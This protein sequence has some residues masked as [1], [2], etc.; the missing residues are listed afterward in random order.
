L[1]SIPDGSEVKLVTDG[2]Y[3]TT[4]AYSN[5]PTRKSMDLIHS[6][7]SPVSGLKPT[8]EHGYGHPGHQENEFVDTLASR[9]AC[10][11]IG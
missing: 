4:V 11:R 5:N 3:G 7:R 1:K 2:P 9:A 6:D 8:F 10:G